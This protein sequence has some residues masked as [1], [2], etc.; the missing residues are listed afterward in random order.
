MSQD[1][2]KLPLFHAIV[3]I[4]TIAAVEHRWSFEKILMA[5][6]SLLILFVSVIGGFCWVIRTGDWR[7]LKEN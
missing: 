1:Q 4:L 6:V 3:L 2:S 7:K 5:I